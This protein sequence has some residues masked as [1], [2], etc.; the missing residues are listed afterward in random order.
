MFES[1]SIGERAKGIGRMDVRVTRRAARAKRRKGN[2]GDGENKCS[3]LAARVSAR[4]GREEQ[5]FGSRVIGERAKK[6]GRTE[7]KSH[8]GDNKQAR[9]GATRTRRVKRRR[10]SAG[11]GV[12]SSLQC[13]Y[14]YDQQPGKIAGK[15]AK[16]HGA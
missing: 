6:M 1:R 5:M 10:A 9:R 4:R 14:Y 7:F 8:E 12:A 13:R 11:A 15:Q 2:R 3:S 16:T